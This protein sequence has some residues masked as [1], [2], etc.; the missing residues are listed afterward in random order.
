MSVHWNGDKELQ[1]I[2]LLCER[3]DARRGGTGLADMKGRVLIQPS[4]RHHHMNELTVILKIGSRLQVE[5]FDTIYREQSSLKDLDQ[6][7]GEMLDSV[8]E[9]DRERACILDQISELRPHLSRRLAQERRRGAHIKGSIGLG[10]LECNEVRD[11][12]PIVCL[13]YLH[14]DLR[15]RRREFLADGTADIDAWLEDIR[16][17]LLFY[18]WSLDVLKAGGAIGQIHPLLLYGLKT[19]GFRVAD[20]IRSRYED[21]EPSWDIGH[22]KDESLVVY[23]HRGVMTGTYTL[24]EG[25]EFQKDS[26]IVSRGALTISKSSQGKDLGKVLGIRGLE[27]IGVTVDEVDTSTGGSQTL[28]LDSEPVPFDEKG[29]LVG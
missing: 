7:V 14:D 18:S 20:T 23:W 21:M 2:K 29:G 12:T 11:A 19:R 6:I 24:A 13:D 9:I 28:W 15:M 5:L 4:V 17:D 16:D 26:V 3:E 22:P 27:G 10:R 1:F 8:E 25:I